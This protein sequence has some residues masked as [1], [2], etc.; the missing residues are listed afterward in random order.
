MRHICELLLRLF[1]LDLIRWNR[2]T[3]VMRQLNSKQDRDQKE[4]GRTLQST[5]FASSPLG[6]NLSLCLSKLGQLTEARPQLL[7]PLCG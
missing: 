4:R 3:F 5:L 1:V 2:N 7:L 6:P